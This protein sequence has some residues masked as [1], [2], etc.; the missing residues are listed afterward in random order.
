MG[1]THRALLSIKGKEGPSLAELIQAYPAEYSQFGYSHLVQLYGMAAVGVGTIEN[2]SSSFCFT[3]FLC[4]E[5]KTTTGDSIHSNF[6]TVSRDIAVAVAVRAII[7]TLDGTN[8]LTS[9]ESHR[10][11]SKE[12]ET[13][14]N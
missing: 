1:R 14:S 13:I 8:A 5:T 7:W 2:T 4:G 3:M 11:T 6:V 12:L 10:F 9:F